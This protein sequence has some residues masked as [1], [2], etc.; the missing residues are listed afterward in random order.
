MKLDKPGRDTLKAYFVKNAV[1]TQSHFEDLIGSQLNQ[2]DDGLAKLPGEPLAL[3]ADGD[4]GSQKKLLNLYRS[5]NDAQPAFTLALSP[6]S[7]PRNAQTAKAG[8]GITDAAGVP[9]LFIDQSSGNL[10]VNTLGSEAR[11]EVAGTLK[12][13]ANHN[14]ARDAGSRLSY[15]GSLV[16]KGNAPQLDFVDTEHGHWAIHVNDSRMYFI[17]DPWNTT[18]LVLDGQGN[19]GLGTAQPRAKLEVRGGAIMPAAG[20]GGNAGLL[21]PPD[22]GGGGGDTA[23]IRFYPRSGEACTLELGVANDGD[24]HISLMASGG[25]GIGTREPRGK[26]EVNGAIYAN[27]SDLY[28]TETDHNHTGI[29]NAPGFAAIENAR[30]YN[31]L[32]LLG[33]NVGTAQAVKRHVEVWD[34][35][36]VNGTFINASDAHAKTAVEPLH[37]GLAEVLKLRPV[38]YEWKS[39]ANP[40]RSIGLIAQEV[41]EVIREV[42]HGDEEGADGR[43]GIAYVNLIPVLVQAL[44]ELT[45]RLQ[46]LEAQSPPSS[47]SAAT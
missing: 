8:L 6:R 10:G 37:Y 28:F 40:Q 24:D 21:F 43:L 30:N 35:L 1:P 3:Q 47:P 27:G 23:W 17:R 41:R 26:L 33:R 39:I 29:G 32:M 9:R 2:R 13:T 45:A 7:D 34:Y 5:F 16:L 19:V 31:A 46:R 44:Q 14:S 38:S 22:P 12:V 4:D 25:V 20:S 42:V 15:G 18:D 11:L 36:K